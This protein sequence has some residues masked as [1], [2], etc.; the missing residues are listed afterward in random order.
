MT[1]PELLQRA[2]KHYLDRDVAAQIM[3]GACPDDVG[4]TL[5]AFIVYELQD[6]YDPTLEEAAQLAAAD[7]AIE[8]GIMDLRTVSKG[9]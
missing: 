3:A 6:T 9:L 8:R 7:K 1:F 4:D 2:F 5:A